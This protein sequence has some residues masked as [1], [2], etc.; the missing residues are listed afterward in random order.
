MVDCEHYNFMRAQLVYDVRW[1]VHDLAHQ[2][3]RHGVVDPAGWNWARAFVR[4]SCRLGSWRRHSRIEA[5]ECA[6]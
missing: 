4:V 3:H 1:A 2:Q 5:V 6:Q